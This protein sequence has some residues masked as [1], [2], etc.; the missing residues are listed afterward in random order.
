V[1]HSA[2]LEALHAWLK[3]D[4]A[5]MGEL[6]ILPDAGAWS[7]RHHRDAGIDGLTLFTRAV[8]ARELARCDAAGKYRPLKTAPTLRRG[9][10]L[11]L[12]SIS[13]VR[14]ALDF[15][16][17][18]MLGTALAAKQKLEPVSFRA[19][20]GR[21]SGMYAVTGKM[22]AEQAD[23]LIGRFCKSDG[24]CLKTILWEIDRG[25]PVT[26]LPPSKFDL[27]VDQTGVHSS[28][29]F[30]PVPCVQPCHLLIAAARAEL[31]RPA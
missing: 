12:P 6:L 21:Q 15:F 1:K 22:P 7:L 17:P 9:W 30:I 2:I 20:A 11:R 23:R 31:K 4:G 29:P 16:Y 3:P 19:T 5:R 18:A 28:L 8:D 27:A 26:S 10:L 14:L 13:E 24:G 25:F